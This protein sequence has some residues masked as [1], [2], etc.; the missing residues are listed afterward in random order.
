M[1]IFDLSTISTNSWSRQ[2]LIDYQ[3]YSLSH[4]TLYEDLLSLFYEKS[5]KKGTV[6]VFYFFFFSSFSLLMWLSVLPYAN[7]TLSFDLR[8][9]HLCIPE[10]ICCKN[11]WYL[12]ISYSSPQ[13]S[14]REMN[15]LLKEKKILHKFLSV[16][17]SSN[18]T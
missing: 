8:N 11:F 16:F 3:S 6:P 7:R 17:N 1:K 12:D 10:V 14:H 4:W 13:R 15:N 9:H 18:C 2:R 5:S